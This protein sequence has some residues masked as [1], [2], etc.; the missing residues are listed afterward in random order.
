MRRVLA[1]AFAA[2]AAAAASAAQQA[3]AC[4][5]CYGAGDNTAMTDGMTYAI[6]GMLLI[7]GVMLG[8]I[9]LL[10]HLFRKRL[11]N[12]AAGHLPEGAPAQSPLTI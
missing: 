7:T 9:A 2:A 3:A 8:T 6:G 1:L 5:S 4:P 11:K 12:I 10:A